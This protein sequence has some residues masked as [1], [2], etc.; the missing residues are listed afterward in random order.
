MQLS[1]GRNIVDAN[2]QIENIV[3]GEP[4]CIEGLANKKG[5]VC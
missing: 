4:H 1:T 3:S 2:I 5:I